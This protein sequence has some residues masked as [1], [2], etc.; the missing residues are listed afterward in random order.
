MMNDNE[1]KSVV[2]ALNHAKADVKGFVKGAKFY[3]AINGAEK[4]GYD[5]ESLEFDVYIAIFMAR[6][7]DRFPNG[8][9]TDSNKVIV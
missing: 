7:N 1:F 6:L 4:H 8:V 5:R 2:T 3:G 9:K